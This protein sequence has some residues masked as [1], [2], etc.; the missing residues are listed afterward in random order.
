[1]I[2][3]HESDDPPVSGDSEKGLVAARTASPWPLERLLFA[4]AGTMTLLRAALAATIS[5]WFLLLTA[6][7]GMN[8]WLYV[9]FAAC[10]ASMVFELAGAERRFRGS[11]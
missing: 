4:V 6:F 7:V 11:E 5:P 2:A 9:I 3:N 8:Q 1:L 10:P